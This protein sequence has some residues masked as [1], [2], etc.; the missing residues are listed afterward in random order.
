M[1]FDTKNTRMIELIIVGMAI[2]DATLDKEKRDER[3]VG[4]MKKELDHL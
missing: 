1:L 3:E 4:T 2:I